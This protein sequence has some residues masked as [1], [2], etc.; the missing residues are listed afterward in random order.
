MIYYVY[1]SRLGFFMD[2]SLLLLFATIVPAIFGIICYLVPGYEWK[3]YVV[4]L[5]AIVLTV[6]SLLVLLGGSQKLAV[7][8]IGVAGLRWREA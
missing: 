7:E 8:A 4:I 1:S 2:G 3:K 5:G 6:A